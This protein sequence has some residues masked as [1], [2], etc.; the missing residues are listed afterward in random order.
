MSRQAI[1]VCLHAWDMC[2]QMG[3]APRARR[4]HGT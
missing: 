3:D 1:F 4:G 2:L